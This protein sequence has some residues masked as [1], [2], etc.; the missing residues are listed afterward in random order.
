MYTVGGQVYNFD[1]PVTKNMTLH[2]NLVGKGYSVQFDANGADGAMSD[3]P[4]TSGTQQNLT[5][6]SFTK[7]G[8]I[9]LG[10]DTDSEATEVKYYDKQ[11]VNN[12]T[13]EDKLTLYAV[14][15]DKKNPELVVETYFE[16][17]DGGF[18]SVATEKESLFVPVDT[19][20]QLS[21]FKKHYEGFSYSYGMANGLHLD[22]ITIHNS[23][24]LVSNYYLRNN[25]TITWKDTDDTILST[26][27]ALYGSNPSDSRVATP[28]YET[29]QHDYAFLGWNTD[30]AATEPLDLSSVTINAD[31]TYYAVY[32]KSAKTNILNINYVYDGT[33]KEAAPS[34]YLRLSKG[35][36][37]LV[38][39]PMIDGYIASEK[40][41]SG[42]LGENT[43]ITVSY[44]PIS[45][46]LT[47]DYRY[48][49]GGTVANSLYEDQPYNNEYEIVSPVVSGY[50]ADK[51]TVSGRITS[52]THILVTYTAKEYKVSFDSSGVSGE[53]PLNLELPSP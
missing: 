37:Y 13:K 30:K 17:I 24:N 49:E 36:D 40:E 14:W 51:L 29:E 41:V 28:S 47:I 12:I 5:A 33:S 32:G 42:T 38:N 9:F 48:A 21:T 3:Q 11:L 4:F 46:S 27:N 23:D 50:T 31:Q 20:H 7:E 45:Y 26:T 39:S 25:Y 53:M 6:C 19:V 43:S 35:E 52:D 22:E 1:T 44:A 16:R 34:V 18:E 10:W 8:K 15:G 2:G